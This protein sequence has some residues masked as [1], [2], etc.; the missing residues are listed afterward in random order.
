MVNISLQKSVCYLPA[1]YIQPKYHFCQHTTLFQSEDYRPSLLLITNKLIVYS[2][3]NKDERGTYDEYIIVP[4]FDLSC[5]GGDGE[6]RTLVPVAQQTHF[7]C[8]P[9]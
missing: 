4:K 2:G 9:L 5:F 7:E 6:I 1:M 8:A 3:S